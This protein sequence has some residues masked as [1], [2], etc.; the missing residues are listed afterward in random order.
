MRDPASPWIVFTSSAPC[1]ISI[2]SN[3]GMVASRKSRTLSRSFSLKLVPQGNQV[4]V[5]QLGPPDIWAEPADA[6]INGFRS[7]L[8]LWSRLQWPERV[9]PSWAAAAPV[10]M[11]RTSP[12]RQARI[13]PPLRG[14]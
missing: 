11:I 13:I 3:T 9:G 5:A 12:A 10:P 4:S 14:P 1:W 2:G 8:S 7:W 6:S